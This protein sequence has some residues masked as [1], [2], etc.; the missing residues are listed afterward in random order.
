MSA[1]AAMERAL[2]RRQ[3]PTQVSL[4]RIPAKTLAVFTRQWS[5][6]MIAG[7]PLVQ[8]FQLLGQSAVGSRQTRQSWV[9]IL[10][11]DRKST[12]LNSSH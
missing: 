11:Q 3:P 6:L 12:R 9:N 1:S 4:H 7:I 10:Q 5:A 2:K 8:A